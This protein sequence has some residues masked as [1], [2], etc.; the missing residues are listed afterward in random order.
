MVREILP[1]FRCVALFFLFVSFFNKLHEE[2]RSEKMTT[3]RKSCG[4]SQMLPRMKTTNGVPHKCRRG[5]GKSEWVVSG[6]SP[7][8]TS[9]MPKLLPT[10]SDEY[11]AYT[12]HQVKPNSRIKRIGISTLSDDYQPL[13][14]S[15]IRLIIQSSQVDSSI[16]LNVGPAQPNRRA[17]TGVKDGFLVGA[18]IDKR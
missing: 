14:H 11:S 3:Q 4:C 12:S 9:I 2:I 10:S 13:D 18:H 16:F 15:N 6:V 17:T 7:A 1:Y 8:S 5:V